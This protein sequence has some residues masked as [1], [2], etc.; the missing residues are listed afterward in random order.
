VSI[1]AL[2]YRARELGRMSD[3]A[4]RRG[5]IWMSQEY[6]R[7]NE[8]GDLGEPEQPVMLRRAAEL[9]F[10]GDPVAE[11][12]TAARLRPA[13]VAEL[14]GSRQD[15]RPKLTPEDLLDGTT[16]IVTGA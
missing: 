2:M 16:P 7:R 8:P 14:L 10:A 3:S 9:A 11:L 1:A 13:L 15:E 5:V 12:A 6:G 4:Y